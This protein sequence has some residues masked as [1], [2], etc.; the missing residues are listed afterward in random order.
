MI[1]IAEMK[2]DIPEEIKKNFDKE[3]YI[4]MLKEKIQ[5]QI[6]GGKNIK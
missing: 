6:E 2:M 4:Q 1:K 3:K 5:K